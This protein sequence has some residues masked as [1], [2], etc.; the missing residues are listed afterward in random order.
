MVKLNIDAQIQYIIEAKN[1]SAIH[2]V[3]MFT[4][5]AYIVAKY[6]LPIKPKT[7]LNNSA[8]LT[9]ALKDDEKI[10]NISSF[11]SET[12]MRQK[13][14][15]QELEHEIER[16]R[17][18]IDTMERKDYYISY[19]IDKAI[20]K[21][22]KVV[23]MVPKYPKQPTNH[24]R[25]EVAM[26]DISDVHLGKKIDYRDT[27]GICEYNTEIFEKQCKLLIEAVNE[28]MEVQRTGGIKINNLYI[29]MLGDLVDGELIYKGHQSQVEYGIHD[30][31]AKHG[32][33]FMQNVLIPLSSIFHK[34]YIIAVN[35]NHGRIGGYKDG[36]DKKANFDGILVRQWESRLKHLGDTYQFRISD[37]PYLMYE[38]LGKLHLLS[39]KS[40][41]TSARSPQLGMERYLSNIGS[42]NRRIIDYLHLAHY[43]RDIKFSS[44]FAEIISNGSW[45][46]PTEFTV[47]ELGAGDYPFQRFY[48]LNERHITWIY[49]IYLD[50]HIMHGERLPYQ[51][52][53]NIL[54][55]TLE[56]FSEIVLPKK[57]YF[58]CD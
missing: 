46:G 43:H 10:K 55:P 54:T 47:G 53:L 58:P 19:L 8:L 14:I 44:N 9:G 1:Y 39:H 41:S 50:E 21:L 51:Q 36:Y 22:P 30:Q 34:I 16:Y 7:L 49:P 45:L 25:Y 15:I 56:P 48:G 27:A 28:I 5:C 40:C 38:L 20:E 37:S 57:K 32:E 31:I 35:G 12:V 13:A 17:K 23:P 11:S 26:L 24:N 3:S 2:G 42:L 6:K 52:E 18:K 33:F 29:N 4:A